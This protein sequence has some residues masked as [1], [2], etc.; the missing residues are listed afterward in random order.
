M[1]PLAIDPATPSA[2]TKFSLLKF[3]ALAT[4]AAAASAPI[5]AVG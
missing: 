1:R 2:L 5:T 4:P 3:K